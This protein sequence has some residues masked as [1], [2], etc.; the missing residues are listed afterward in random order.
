MRQVEPKA[1][2]SGITKVPAETG[3]WRGFGREK[4]FDR[5]TLDAAFGTPSISIV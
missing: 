4:D 2:W 5:R 1:P 3:V